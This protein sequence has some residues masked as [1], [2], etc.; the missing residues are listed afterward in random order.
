MIR[1]E[2]S[3]A[4]GHNQWPLPEQ[5]NGAQTLKR[6][7]PKLLSWGS[8]RSCSLDWVSGAA[9]ADWCLNV[10]ERIQLNFNLNGPIRYFFMVRFSPLDKNSQTLVDTTVRDSWGQ[11]YTR[12]W[13]GEGGHP[14]NSLISTLSLTLVV[15]LTV[16]NLLEMTLNG[17][18]KL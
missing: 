15:G 9:T 11:T 12:T 14:R 16:E 13:P 7:T 8:N 5:R 4:I 17:S 18:V 10:K 6:W 2:N 3:S 1:R